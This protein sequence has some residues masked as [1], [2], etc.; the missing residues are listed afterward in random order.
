M[1]SMRLPPQMVGNVGLYYVCYRLSLQGWNVMPTT[2]NAKGVDILAYSSQDASR[3]VTIQVKALSERSPVPLGGKLDN[4]FAQFVI[5]CRRVTSEQPESFVLTSSEIRK[6]VVRNEK[7]NKI[8]YWLNP[9][10]YESEKYR[11]KWDRLGTGFPG[12]G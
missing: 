4:L 7:D 2:R 12:R 3:T 8:S 10:D 5:I 11:E 9:R 6:A 1:N